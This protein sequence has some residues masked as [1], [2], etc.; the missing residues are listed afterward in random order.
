MARTARILSK[1]G[2]S[3]VIIRGVA[4]MTIFSERQDYLYFIKLMREYANET[5]VLVCV[6]CLMNNHV[7]MLIY[8]ANAC[9]SQFMRKLEVCYSH[10]FNTK[11]E[12][13]GHVFQNRF[14]AKAV[15]D[16]AY[17]N[18]VVRYILLNPEKAGLCHAMAYEWSSAFD[19]V[20]N[21]NDR[22]LQLLRDLL[23]GYKGLDEFLSGKGDCFDD[24][25]ELEGISRDE[26]WA[27]DKAKEILGTPDVGSIASMDVKE[28]NRVIRQ[29]LNVGINGAQIAR[30]TGLSRGVIR[31][32]K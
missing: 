17:M 15:E 18:M 12:R 31:N 29:M 21:M 7:H 6:Y 1:S 13:T 24:E 2:Y 16:E 10:Y 3:H 5:G 4:K 27:K 25:S 22:E 19:Y 32:A 20:H 14:I 11:K 30:M 9:I 23:R 28:R 8:D 26:G